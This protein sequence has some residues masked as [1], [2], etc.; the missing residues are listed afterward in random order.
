MKTYE[1]F[2]QNAEKPHIEARNWTDPTNE[3]EKP[4]G[5]RIFEILVDFGPADQREALDEA[6]RLIHQRYNE[7]LCQ[8]KE[9]AESISKQ[10]E[11]FKGKQ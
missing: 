2:Y 5:I 11:I 1:R 7:R 4:L 8:I 6:E 9:E 3:E 10:W